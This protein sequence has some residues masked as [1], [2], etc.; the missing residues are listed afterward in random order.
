MKWT[1]ITPESHIS[2]LKIK[3]KIEFYNIKDPDLL[4]NQDICVI[5]VIPDVFLS[6]FFPFIEEPLG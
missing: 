5:T 4:N 3:F 2:I 1:T 6:L